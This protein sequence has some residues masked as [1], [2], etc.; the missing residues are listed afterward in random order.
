MPVYKY[1]A[2]NASGQEV[3]DEV[4]APSSEE[5]VTKI[6]NLGLFPTRISEKAATRRVQA[7]AGPGAQKK[8]S[9]PMGRVSGKLLT[10]FTRQLSTLIDAGLPILRCLSILEQQQRPGILRVTLRRVR[11]DVEGG[12]SLSEAMARNPKVFNRLYVNMVA[13]GETGGVLDTI[14]S[15][16]ADFLEKAQWLRRRVIGAMIYPIAVIVVAALIVTGIMM[17]V[18]PKFQTIFKDMGADLPAPTKILLSMSKWFVA[19]G[20]LVILFAPLAVFIIFRVM[21]LSRGGRMLGDKIKLKIPL[22]GKILSKTAIARFS[23]T[24]GTL[25]EAG[26]PILEALNITRNTAGNE[27][28]AR[29]IGDVHDSVREGETFADPLRASKVCDPI[30][31]NMVDVG[32]ETGDLDKMLLKVADNYDEEVDATV[33]ALVSVIEPIMVVVLGGICGFIVVAI[34]L[35]LPTMISAASGSAR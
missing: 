2:M 34:F 28:F 26:V 16:L 30:V 27:V 11:E 7:A 25:I 17:V 29:A 9:T 20:W 14:L 21:R 13:A 19:G 23:R 12:S 18:I 31:V 24:L 22:V 3:K 8:T 6:R 33:T 35:P 15:R 32:E 10:Q 4:Q 1:E 5:A